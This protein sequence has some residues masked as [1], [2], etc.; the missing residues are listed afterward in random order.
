MQQFEI[1]AEPT[2]DLQSIYGTKLTMNCN[3]S[4][5]LIFFI[6]LVYGPKFEK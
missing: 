2:Q 5:L 6:K 4:D 1:I 3:I